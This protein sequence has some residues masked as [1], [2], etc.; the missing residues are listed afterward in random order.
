MKPS[1]EKPCIVVPIILDRYQERC[2]WDKGFGL[3]LRTN[4]PDHGFETHGLLAC[5]FAPIGHTW[6]GAGWICLSLA[7]TALFWLAEGWSWYRPW[8]SDYLGHVIP[9]EKNYCCYQFWATGTDMS[10]HSLSP[11][12]SF[13]LVALL[14][15]YLIHDSFKPKLP[16]LNENS[17]FLT[18]SLL[19]TTWSKAF[20]VYNLLKSFIPMPLYPNDFQ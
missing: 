12:V 19:S 16:G 1:N 10:H 5:P 17:T 13:W 9:L 14:H 20:I 15:P 2:S 18:N 6:G 7:V 3:V 11:Y 4:I 8:A